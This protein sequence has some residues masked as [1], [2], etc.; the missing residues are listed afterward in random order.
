M[1][2]LALLVLFT[3]PS[4]S[5]LWIAVSQ[6]ILVRA[7]VEGECYRPA[8]GTDAPTIIVTPYGSYCVTDPPLTVVNKLENSK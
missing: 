7:P 1:K 2:A 3:S 8:A 6:V 5:P 4:H